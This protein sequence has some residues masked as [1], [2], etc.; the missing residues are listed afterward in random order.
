VYSKAA[1]GA[2]KPVVET[3]IVSPPP[4]TSL[5]VQVTNQL[6]QAASGM[7]VHITGPSSTSAFTSANGCAIL[8]VSPGEYEVNVHQT[9]YL[10][11]NWFKESK[12]D[13][14][15][16]DPLDVYLPAETTTKKEYVFALAAAV[17]KLEFEELNPTTGAHESA[18]AVNAIMENSQMAPATRLLLPE[19]SSTYLSSIGPTEKHIFPFLAAEPYAVYAGTCSA[20]RPPE[21][22]RTKVIFSAGGEASA[23]VLLPSLIVDVW[24]NSQ[25]EW[26]KETKPRK[27]ITSKPE[28][29]LSDTDE[30]C[31]NTYRQ[32]ETIEKQTETGGALKYPGQPWGT[33]T[34]CVNVA[35]KNTKTAKTE[36]KY[37]EVP[38]LKNSNPKKEGTVVN[39]YEGGTKGEGLLPAGEGSGA[40]QSCP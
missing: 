20:N 1:F 18:R 25:K 30:G 16:P 12:E 39:L 37:F 24:Q 23:K 38:G 26:E 4:D 3:G 27:L 8:A 22:E 36:H 19:K 5:I 32:P 35:Y 2:T 31:E 9:G 14:S 6:D 34:V 21:A 28:I 7:E 40:E 29:F 13:T 15:S 10:D 17:K 11:P 33:Y